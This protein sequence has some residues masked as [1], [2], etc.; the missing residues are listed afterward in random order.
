MSA[1]LADA[2]VLAEG[3]QTVAYSYIGPDLTTPIYT[4]GTIGRAKEHLEDSAARINARF[5][6]ASAY[7]SVNKAL[8][9]RPVPPSP[10]FPSTFRCSTK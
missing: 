7:V 4:N 8:V 9:T 1:A 10:L 3:F 5:G 6:D 2:G